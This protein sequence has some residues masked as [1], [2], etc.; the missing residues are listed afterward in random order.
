MAA[1]EQL[2]IIRQGIAPWNEWR[3]KNPDVSRPDLSQANLTGA[4]LIQ[5]DLRNASAR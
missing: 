3:V 1:E 5:T 4:L 2:E